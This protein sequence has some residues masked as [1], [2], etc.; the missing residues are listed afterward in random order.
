MMVKSTLQLN[1][2]LAGLLMELG[3]YIVVSTGWILQL[4][5]GTGIIS[6][7]M[8]NPQEVKLYEGFQKLLAIIITFSETLVYSCGAL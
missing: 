5:V 2:L 7:D 3:V 4:L 1:V 6:L 8:H